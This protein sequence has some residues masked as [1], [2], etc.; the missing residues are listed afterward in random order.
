MDRGN[1]NFR[2]KSGREGHGGLWMDLLPGRYLGAESFDQTIRVH[3]DVFWFLE[4]AIKK[5]SAQ[6]ARPYAHYGVTA[7]SRAE[8]ENILR[9]WEDLTKLLETAVIPLDL[10][11][12]QEVPKHVRRDFI[13][14]L[15]RNERKLSRLIGRLALWVRAEIKTHEE[16]S[17]L[18]I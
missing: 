13:R 4:P 7:I 1:L 16:V 18:G 2:L 17:I 12:L 6:Y 14:S 11:V 9:E 15:I 3:E 8:W 5:Y 10:K